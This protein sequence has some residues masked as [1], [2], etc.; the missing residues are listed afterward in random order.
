MISEKSRTNR[1]I[2]VRYM[3]FACVI[4]HF[5]YIYLVKFN[6]HENVPTDD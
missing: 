3:Y 2:G 4:H 5:L 6:Y 1:E